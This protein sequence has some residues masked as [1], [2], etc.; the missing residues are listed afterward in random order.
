MTSFS[1]QTFGCRSNQAE[2]FLWANEF[3]KHGLKYEKD[4][5]RSDLIVVNSCT[6]TGRADSDTRSF[7]RRVSRL[8]PKARLI[9]TGCYAQRAPEELKN[10]PQVSCLLSNTEKKDLDAK[11]LS[12]AGPGK[13]RQISPFRSRASVKI[14]DGCNFQCT[15]CIIPSVRGKS[16]SLEKKEIL[17]RIKEFISQGSREIV[18]TGIHLCSYG[19]DLNTKSSLLE[20]LQEIESLKELRKLRLSSLDPR[21]LSPSLIEHITASGK[22]CPHFHLSLQSGSDDILHRMGRKIQIED[23]TN[24]LT[25]LREKSPRASLGAD[26]I[27]GFPGETGE[28]FSQTYSFLEQ[29]P[30]TYLHVFSYSPRPG[31]AAASW[32]Q[33][34][35]K[36]KKER[37]RLLRD[38]SSRKNTNFRRLF[39][40]KECEAIVIKKEKARTEV[41][42]SNYFKVF[43]P[44]C[45]QNEGK[46]VKVKITKVDTKKTTGQIVNSSSS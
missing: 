13:E 44:S 24:I 19:L 11:I 10:M 26:I 16:V 20:L 15:F 31:T 28:D 37:A 34:N 29:S 7:I 21:F 36:V 39:V 8:N 41:L 22:V 2:A 38:L 5:S 30:L 40:G 35:G 32:Q 45:S 3:Q 6:L 12:F 43:I 17:A 25:L 14:Q 9:V 18:L 42:T 4:F 27:V 23:Y 1:I 33:V 46:E